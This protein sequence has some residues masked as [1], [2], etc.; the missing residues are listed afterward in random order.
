MAWQTTS[1]ND[2][3]WRA[4][5]RQLNDEVS[6]WLAALKSEREVSGIEL[7]GVVGSVI[8]LA[9]HLGAIRQISAAARGPRATD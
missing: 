4:L 8:H 9:Y 7:D 3:Q 1:V 5:R 6:D 2:E